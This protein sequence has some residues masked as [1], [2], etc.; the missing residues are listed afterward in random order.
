MQRL[1]YMC[2]LFESS[3]ITSGTF[4][5]NRL[6]AV[7]CETYTGTAAGEAA[8]MLELVGTMALQAGNATRYKWV[9]TTGFYSSYGIG[10]FEYLS[11]CPQNCTSIHAIAKSCNRKESRDGALALIMVML[12]LCPHNIN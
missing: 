5:A 3:C 1:A 12:Y 11:G 9:P 6:A 8:T 10:R 4:Q 2:S 7:F